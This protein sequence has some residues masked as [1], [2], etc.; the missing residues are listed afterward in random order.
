MLETDFRALAA[1]AALALCLET[2]AID[3]DGAVEMIFDR[4]SDP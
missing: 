1:V 3:D 4:G 2:T